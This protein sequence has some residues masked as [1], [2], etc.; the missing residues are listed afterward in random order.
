MTGKYTITKRRAKEDA[1]KRGKTSARNLALYH[2]YKIGIP[3]PEIQFKYKDSTGKPLTSTRVYQIIS[4][5]RYYEQ[6]EGK[7]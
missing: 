7:E 6:K 5:E 2:D 4:K 1:I 3:V